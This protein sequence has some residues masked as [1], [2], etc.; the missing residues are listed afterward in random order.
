MKWAS[1]VL[2]LLFGPLLSWIDSR[3]NWDDTGIT[4]GCLLLAAFLCAALGA[5]PWWLVALLVG[6]LIPIVA[7]ARYSNLGSLL[8]IVPAIFGSL[9]GF[10][11]AGRRE[12]RPSVTPT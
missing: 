2:A 6:A 10:R 5:R 8:A 7:I 1:L 12:S 11:V 3:P 9:A 4:F